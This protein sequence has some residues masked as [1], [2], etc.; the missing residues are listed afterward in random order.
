[1]YPDE[2][3]FPGGEQSTYT[4]AAVILAA[5]ALAQ[6]TPAATLFTDHRFLPSLI[7]TAEPVDAPVGDRD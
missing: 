3:H 7:D 6:S 5:D 4:A 2:V 1:M